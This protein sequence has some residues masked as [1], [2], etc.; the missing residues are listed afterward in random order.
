MATNRRAS[1]LRLVAVEGAQIAPPPRPRNRD[2][3]LGQ[4]WEVTLAIIREHMDHIRHLVDRLRSL[5]RESELS[6][7]I[8]MPT[9]DFPNPFD[10]SA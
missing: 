3:E 2:A 8:S 5:S 10:P 9:P 1:H 6:G 7:N 4:E